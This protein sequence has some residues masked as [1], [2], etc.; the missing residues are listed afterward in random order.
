MNSEIDNKKSGANKHCAHPA[1]ELISL[2]HLGRPWGVLD[3]SF[4]FSPEFI[5]I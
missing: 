3:W 2:P 4:F 1:T 5:I